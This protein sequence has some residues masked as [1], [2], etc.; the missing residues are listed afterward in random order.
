MDRY[1][2]ITYQ[3]TQHSKKF[4][5]PHKWS[6]DTT[7]YQSKCK[8]DSSY[9]YKQA[10]SKIHLSPGQGT[11]RAQAILKK[12]KVREMR[13]STFHTYLSII[14]AL[15]HWWFD[16]QPDTWYRRDIPKGLYKHGQLAFSVRA[17][18]PHLKLYIKTTSKLCGSNCNI[19][20][21]HFQ[22]R[23]HTKVYLRVQGQLSCW[24]YQ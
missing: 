11:G 5:F 10:D 6:I 4:Q 8:H 7:Q 17:S 15:W 19:K 12:K 14:K 18:V 9:S 13:P 1:T 23:A 20:V 24:K 21:Y 3:K 22:E 2:V 16:R